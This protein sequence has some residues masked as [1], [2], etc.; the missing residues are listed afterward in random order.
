ML[1][2][3]HCSDLRTF[4]SNTISRSRRTA[5]LKQLGTPPCVS[6]RERQIHPLTC[7]FR[8]CALLVLPS[9]GISCTEIGTVHSFISWF[10]I[11]GF[12]AKR[13]LQRFRSENRAPLIKRQTR[14]S[15]YSSPA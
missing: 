3:P 8:P 1:P 2:G 11:Y 10:R 13:L 12:L 5:F 4:S 6:S 14:Y 9:L 7:G 15:N